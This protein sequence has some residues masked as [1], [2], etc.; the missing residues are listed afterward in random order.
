[1]VY[2]D[3][4]MVRAGMVDHTSQWHL[5]GYREIQEPRRKNV[6]IDYGRLPE[7][8]GA[9]SYG[10]LRRRYRGWVEEYLGERKRDR[11]GE[12]TGSIALGNRP[13]VDKVKEHL[14]FRAKGRKITRS[15]EGYQLR[16]PTAY[17]KPLLEK[18]KEDIGPENTYLW[19]FNI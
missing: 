13:F 12:W 16:E 15:G 11:E 4:N 2:I 19:E 6:L 14:G 9:E 3:T 17:Y 10:Q 18:E 5:S 8:F 7:M 1:M